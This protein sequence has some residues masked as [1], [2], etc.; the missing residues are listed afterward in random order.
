MNITILVVT[1][2][3]TLPLAALSVWAWIATRRLQ[4]ALSAGFEGIHFEY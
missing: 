2:A 1:A 4:E 3:I